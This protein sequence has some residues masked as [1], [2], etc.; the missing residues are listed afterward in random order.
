MQFSK[1][2]ARAD[3]KARRTGI[4]TGLRMDLTNVPITRTLDCGQDASNRYSR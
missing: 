4:R 1:P 3:K 2:V